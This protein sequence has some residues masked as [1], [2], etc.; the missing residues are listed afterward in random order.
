MI[1]QLT[2]TT[3]Y[4][5]MEITRGTISYETRQEFYEGLQSLIQHTTLI[6]EANAETLTITLNGGH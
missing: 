5:K 4:N 1:P 6:F 3:E 2:T